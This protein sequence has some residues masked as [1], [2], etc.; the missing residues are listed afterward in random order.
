MEIVH[1]I[2]TTWTNS[3][4]Q[5]AS[6]VLSEIR[7]TLMLCCDHVE[8]IHSTVS[9]MSVYYGDCVSDQQWFHVKSL[10]L[11]TRFDLREMLSQSLVSVPSIE[12]LSLRSKPN[13]MINGELNFTL[14]SVNVLTLIDFHY[15]AIMTSTVGQKLSRE[16][17]PN[18]QQLN[19]WFHN[20]ICTYRKG[21]VMSVSHL[22]STCS[23]HTNKYI[24]D[25]TIMENHGDRVFVDLNYKLTKLEDD[26]GQLLN[27]KLIIVSG[28]ERRIAI[29]N[30][31]IRDWGVDL[32]RN[33]WKKD[34]TGL[35]AVCPNMNSQQLNR[36]MVESLSKTK[37]QETII[38]HMQVMS[39]EYYKLN[40]PELTPEIKH[41]IGS[42]KSNNEKYMKWI[43]YWWMINKN[44]TKEKLT[45]LFETFCEDNDSFYLYICKYIHKT[46][47]PVG[48]QY[49]I[50]VCEPAMRTKIL[51]YFDYNSTQPVSG[52]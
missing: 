30:K 20:P 3:N 41:V 12:N 17:V 38:R 51:E 35:L 40:N 23:I 52:V 2:A 21:K 11:Y 33:F 27:K 31:T 49:W 19:L 1:L 37:Y 43:F 39:M 10:D 29:H 26:L 15:G 50:N 44:P 6:T 22:P 34:V 28:I 42:I 24:F 18:I 36:T 46:I 9:P 48:V 7:N 47:G 13:H 45:Q 14:P 8:Y 16:F 5:S 32:R 25:R 4:M